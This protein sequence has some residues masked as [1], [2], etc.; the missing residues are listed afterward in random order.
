MN[1]FITGKK[2]HLRKTY[3]KQ[4]PSPDT[5]AKIQSSRVWQMENEFYEFVLQQ[6]HFLRKRTLTIKDGVI[7]DKGQ[8]FMYEKIR[9]R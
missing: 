5:V 1:L 7:A 9:P 4:E 2:S 6:F 3:N 8:Q